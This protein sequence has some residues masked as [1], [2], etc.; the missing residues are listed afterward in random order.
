MLI[1]R[2]SFGHLE[3]VFVPLSTFR[4]SHR[5]LWPRGA[6]IMWPTLHC[7]TGSGAGAELGMSQ[8]LRVRRQGRGL[9]AKAHGL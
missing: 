8:T 7:P 3:S 6:P 4:T 2:L 5:V 9:V 1:P